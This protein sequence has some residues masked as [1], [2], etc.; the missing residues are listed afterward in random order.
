MSIKYN[1]V[2]KPEPGVVGGGTK[3]WYAI[4]KLDGEITVDELSK[5]IEKFSSLSE[6]DIR[7]VII[8]LETVIQNQII[9]GKIIRL[10]KLGSF[11]P[12]ISSNGA[13]T[14]ADYNSNMIKSI[15]INYRPG[16]RILD[17]L[18]TAKF[19]KAK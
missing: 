15:K 12:S 5:E 4:A 3:K 1:V 2:Q 11:Y 8:A 6:V 17:A 19:T 7:G 14:E 16:A 18:K 10:D 9:N 13:A